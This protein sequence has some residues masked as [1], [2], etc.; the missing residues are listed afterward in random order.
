MHLSDIVSAIQPVD[1]E[2]IAKARKK[3]AQL[4]MPARAL[5]RLHEISERLCGIQQTLQPSIERK[6]VLVMAGDHGIAG[7]GVSAYPQEV[8]G[9]MVKTFLAGGAGINAISRH[10]GADVLVVDVGTMTDFDTTN[11]PGR[12]RLLVRK[13]ARGTASFI[14]GPAMSLREAEQSILYGFQAAAELFQDGVEIIGTGDMG[15]GNTTPSAAIGTVIC[16]VGPAEMVGRGTGVDEEGLVRKRDAVCRGIEVNHPKPDDGLDILSKVG[17][18]EIGGIAGIALAGAFHGRPVM[19]DGF[20]S[21]AGAL[22]ADLLCPRVK[23]YLFAGHCSAE[24]G[25][26]HMLNHLNLNPILDLGMRLGEGTGG[27]LAMS[28]VDGALKV[29]R[30]V[31]TFEEAGVAGKE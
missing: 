26:R 8:T 21:T 14:R 27:A 9:A 25:H 24:H 10:V 6:A 28:I 16:K 17:G 7:E 22:I 19:I 31:M 15:I 11:M 3:T 1:Q 18:F 4:V 2:W 5:G 30:E 20:I 29:F 23:D 12:E 13:V